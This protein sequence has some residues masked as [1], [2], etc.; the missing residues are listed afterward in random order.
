MNTLYIEPFGGMAGDMFLAALLDLGD[1]RFR[2]E[3]LRELA[4]ELVPEGVELA[5]ERVWRGSLSGLHL[6]VRTPES[7]EAPHRRLADLLELVEASPLGSAARGRVERVLRCL[8]EAEGRVHDAAPEEIH[9]HEV[10]AVDTLVDVCGAALALERL[11]VERVFA[12]PPL[13][14][15]GSVHCAHG[16][17]PVPAPAVVELLRGRPCLLGGGDGERTTPTAAALLVSLCADFTSP[18]AFRAASVGYGAGTKE[19]SEGPPN[20]VRVQL[21]ERPAAPDAEQRVA[22]LLEVNLDDMTG[23]EIGFAVRSLREAGA[24]EVW[25]QPVQMKKD[26]PGVLLSAL[27]REEQRA[28]LEQLVFARTTTLGV[29][30]RE[31]ERTERVRETRTLAVEGVSVRVK[32]PRGA[33]ELGKPEA[34]D[35]EA[36]ARARGWSLRRARAAALEQWRLEHE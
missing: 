4:R 29:R 27:A 25:T 14:G 33:P 3:D 30:W 16:A 20:L 8:A 17:M 12:A 10:G 36:L 6:E 1:E 19:F 18:G 11:G 31:V 9:F 23:E 24:L 32:Y 5:S 21:G 34:D 22:W 35:L 26:R 7:R 15:S 28:E 2:L 13:L